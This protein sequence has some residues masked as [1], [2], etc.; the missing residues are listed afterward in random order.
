MNIVFN[1]PRNICCGYLLE[2]PRQGDSNKY[3]QHVF[4]GVNKGQ[5]SFISFIRLVHIGILYSGK[6]F[7]TAESWGTNVV[8]IARFLGIIIRL[9]LTLGF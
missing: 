1:T 6:F 8:V 9:L 5:K 2:S 4:L 3:I 7:I